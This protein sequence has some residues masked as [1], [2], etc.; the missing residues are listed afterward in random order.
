MRILA[1]DTSSNVATAAIMDGDKLVCEFVLNNKM[2]HSQTIMPI[3]DECFKKSE[4]TPKD[5]DLFAVA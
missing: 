1:V 5:I 3:I 4:L 2:T